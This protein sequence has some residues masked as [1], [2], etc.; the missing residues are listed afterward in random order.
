MKRSQLTLL[1]VFGIAGQIFLY[2]IGLVIIL[3]AARVFATWFVRDV[4]VNN[5]YLIPLVVPIIFGF[6]ILLASKKLRHKAKQASLN[7]FKK[8][9]KL[10]KKLYKRSQL[11]VPKNILT[12]LVLNIGFVVIWNGVCILISDYIR[13]FHWWLKM[14]PLYVP[15]MWTV[16]LP[17]ILFITFILWYKNIK[18]IPNTFIKAKKET[19][20]RLKSTT[21]Y[22]SKSNISDA[23]ELKKYADLRDQGVITEE[24]FQA[25]KR[26]LL[27]L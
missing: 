19:T 1:K 5:P 11:L 7:L 17:P 8:L 9:F 22:L 21:K 23:D 16:F 27:D 12:R 20:R 25:K 13:D 10:P 18:D 6:L 3:G 26:Q 4:L 2:L 24:E 14:S 15:F